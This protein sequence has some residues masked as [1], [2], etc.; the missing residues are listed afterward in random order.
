MSDLEREGLDLWRRYRAAAEPL[1]GAHP[2]DPEPDVGLLAAYAE[3]RLDEDAA[4]PVEAWLAR[5]PARLALLGPVADDATPAPL[6]V[7]RNAR[8]LVQPA[9][10][11]T[12]RQAVAWASVA[13]SLVLVGAS[14]FIAGHQA[15]DFHEALTWAAGGDLI[16]GPGGES[17]GAVF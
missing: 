1:P 2:G 15:D 12:W 17:D 8:A 10:R 11:Q 16:Y 13:A 5:D 7:I 6:A 3:G 4:A 9:P 14:G